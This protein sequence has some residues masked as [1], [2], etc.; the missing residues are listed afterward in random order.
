[1]DIKQIETETRQEVAVYVEPIK[2]FLVVS[3]QTMQ[4][5]NDTIKEINKRIKLVDEKFEPLMA[6]QVEAKRKA[7]VA[8][9][10]LDKLIEEIKAP[11][12]AVKEY[13]VRA[14]KDYDTEQKAIRDEAE[15][16]AREVARKAED[17]RQ[18]REAEEAEKAGNH[19]E[20]EEILK[21]ERQVSA[22]PPPPPAYK[23]DQRLFP[24]KWKARVT[25]KKTVIKF[26]AANPQYTELLEVDQAAINRLAVSMKSNLRIDGIIAYEE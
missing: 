24:K 23:V 17:E 19:E 1:M 4:A 14:G 26:V 9:A 12:M 25:D 6:A 15:R 21:E 10:E 7:T 18:L 2:S 22:P 3:D 8:K 13:L 20:A 16:I 11:L 5:A